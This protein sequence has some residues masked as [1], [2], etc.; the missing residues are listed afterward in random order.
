MGIEAGGCSAIAPEVPDFVTGVAA[1][2][3]L[4]ERERIGVTA[5]RGEGVQVPETG[6]SAVL[7]LE[8]KRQLNFDQKRQL[9][10]GAE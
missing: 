7:A 3:G 5:K 10:A 6:I 9:Y 8:G 2:G 1:P 4:A